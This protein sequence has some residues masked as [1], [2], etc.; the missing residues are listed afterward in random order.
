MKLQQELQRYQLELL[1][2]KSRMFELE[3]RLKELI[4]IIQALELGAKREEEL[5][6]K[7]SSK[8]E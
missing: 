4:V 7:L 6:S 5:L 1:N 2:T 8:S 3:T